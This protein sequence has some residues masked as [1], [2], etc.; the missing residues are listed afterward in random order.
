MADIVT[1]FDLWDDYNLNAVATAN[2]KP[3]DVRRRAGNFWR[4]AAL[5]PLEGKYG[6]SSIL[7]STRS[8]ALLDSTGWHVLWSLLY[9]N[10]MLA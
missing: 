1:W 9:T 3:A 7:I 5:T 2:L 10:Y 6:F 8:A 4:F